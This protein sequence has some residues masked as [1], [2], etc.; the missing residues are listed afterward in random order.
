MA[1]NP[2]LITV[3]DVSSFLI[4][5]NQVVEQLGEHDMAKT[6]FWHEVVQNAQPLLY[7]DFNGS[8]LTIGPG[9]GLL[10][11]AEQLAHGRES[12]VKPRHLGIVK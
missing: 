4:T 10:R 11:L 8:M 3:I 2:H 1:S 6:S 5:F 12:S 9:S 7:L